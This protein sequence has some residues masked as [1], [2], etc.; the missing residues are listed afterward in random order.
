MSSYNIPSKRPLIAAHRG[1]YGSSIPCNTLDAFDIA[2][3]KG[4]DIIETDVQRSVD[5][6]MFLFHSGMEHVFLGNPD[7]HLDQMTGE[8][9]SRLYLVNDSLNPTYYR[10]PTLDDGLEQLKGCCLINLDR[11]EDFWEELVPYI[12]RHGMAEQILFKS[13]ANPEYFKRMEALG[14]R[15]CY[16]PVVYERDNASSFLE[17]MNIR[18]GGLEVVFNSENS[19]LCQPEYIESQHAAGRLLW[20]NCII[21]SREKSLCAGHDDE[22]SMT[23]N[24]KEGW[25]WCIDK[26]FDIIQTDWTGELNDFRD[27]GI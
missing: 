1:V 7:I 24:Q 6:Q 22:R 23:V 4:A 13:A 2:L 26:G 3:R 25:G 18:F 20:V 19:P 8:E 17:G 10:L 11:C 5:G 12:E 14:N 9:I 21:I 15:Y 27:T 16:F